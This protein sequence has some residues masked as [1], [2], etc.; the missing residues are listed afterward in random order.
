M[1]D[2]QSGSLIYGSPGISRIYGLPLEV[3]FNNPTAWKEVVYEEDLPVVAAMEKATF[4]GKS[5]SGEYRI[6]RPDGSV[7]WVSERTICE[8]DENGQLV[9]ILGFVTD[10]HE[11]K[12]M[13]LN[14]RRLAAMLE[15]TSDFASI[16]SPQGQ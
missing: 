1:V 14:L 11:Q 7:H 15:Q 9:R 5:S 16:A 3:F 2:P 13:E 10:I 12:S 4:A 8:F 6:R